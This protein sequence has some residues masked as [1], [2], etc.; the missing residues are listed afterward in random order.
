MIVENLKRLHVV[1]ILL[2]RPFTL[3]EEILKVSEPF[4]EQFFYKGMEL[5]ALN[6]SQLLKT[7]NKSNFAVQCFIVKKWI[8]VIHNNMPKK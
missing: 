7:V 6:Y 3:S 2:L 5:L 4:F 1:F 8:S